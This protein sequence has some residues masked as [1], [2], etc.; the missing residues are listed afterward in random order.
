V[1]IDIAEVF[2]KKQHFTP[3]NWERR[4]V[5]ATRLLFWPFDKGLLIKSIFSSSRSPACGGAVAISVFDLLGMG[6]YI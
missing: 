2:G 5:N 1:R 6:P 4:D 3:F